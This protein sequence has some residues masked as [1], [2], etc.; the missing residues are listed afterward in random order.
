MTS[1]QTVLLYSHSKG[2]EHELE[3]GAEKL[4]L[5]WYLRPDADVGFRILER[6][7]MIRRFVSWFKIRFLFTDEQL[8]DAVD[9]VDRVDRKKLNDERVWKSAQAA[10]VYIIRELLRRGRTEYID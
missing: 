5:G 10:K 8:M 9:F 2:A 7:V 6:M 1:T 4:G 3:A